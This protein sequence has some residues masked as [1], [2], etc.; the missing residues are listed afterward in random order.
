MKWHAAAET[1]IFSIKNFLCH[2]F[3]DKVNVL[4]LKPDITL[5]IQKMIIT[6]KQQ[7]WLFHF[8]KKNLQK[9]RKLFERQQKAL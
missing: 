8:C 1:N 7:N 3:W 6:N 5:K 4:N 9:S 2:K